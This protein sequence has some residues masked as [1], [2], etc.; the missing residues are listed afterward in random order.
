MGSSYRT[1]LRRGSMAE[2]EAGLRTCVRILGETI[3]EWQMYIGDDGQ[4]DNAAD[5]GGLIE[6]LEIARDLIADTI[7][8]STL[9]PYNGAV[10][11]EEVG[12]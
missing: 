1:D 9:P 11:G 4:Y 8:R 5:D 10:Q 12:A 7:P 6:R 2:A 3:A